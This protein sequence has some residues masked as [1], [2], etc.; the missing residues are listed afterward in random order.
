MILA[1]NRLAAGWRFHQQGK[2]PQA[3]IIYRSV[4]RDFPKRADAWVYLGMVLNDREHYHEALAAYEHALAI[5]P[6]NASAW[7][8]RGNTLG[9]LSRHI[10]A[11]A[12]HKKALALSPSFARGHTNLGVQLLR[13]GDMSAGW[14]EYD[15]RLKTAI[16]S[17]PECGIPF[18]KNESLHGK[19]IL[20]H[21]EQGLGDEIQ[22]AR[23]AIVL[24]K[25]QAQVTLTASPKLIPLLSRS[26]P[27]CE[28]IPRGGPLPLADY[29][30]C[31]FSLVSKLGVG[32][33][34][35]Y[36]VADPKLSAAWAADLLQFNGLKVGICW[37]G[38]SENPMNRARSFSLRSFV[39]LMPAENICLVSLQ[40]L[41]GQEE[42]DAMSKTHQIY[43]PLEAVN[44]NT[45]KSLDEMAALVTN[46]D[47][48][49]TCDSMTAHLAPALGTP[50]WLAL[51]A[52]PDWRWGLQSHL[53]PWYEKS[54]LFRQ[55]RLGDW[56]SVFSQI[57]KALAE[58][59]TNGVVRSAKTPELDSLLTECV[60]RQQGRHGVFYYLRD[61]IYIG[62]SLRHYGEFSEP[63]VTLFEQ[64]VKTGDTVVEVGSN[65][66]THTIPLGRMVG[67]TGKVLAFEPQRFIYQ[68]LQKNIAENQLT[69]IDARRVALADCPGT[70][71]VPVLDP[72]AENN[73][74]GVPIGRNEGGDQV[75]VAT[76]DSL[77]LSRCAL[78]KA[79]VEGMEIH[80]IRGASETIKK[81]KPILYLEND[82]RYQ[83]AELIAL[84]KSLGHR[85]YSHTPK[86]FNENNFFGNDNNI[87]NDICSQNILCVPLTKQL[88]IKGL[89]EL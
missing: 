67:E 74:G 11:L 80:V 24:A 39:E 61:D 83:S 75:S 30:I 89:N 12:S 18:W 17:P 57:G 52:G 54:Q 37:T 34:S 32:R 4:L 88:E 73:F 60:E 46:L 41:H 36:L 26:L 31:G 49:I 29:Q 5:E 14:Q 28:V 42:L 72:R 27:G 40:A 25:Q 76:L 65:I 81:C 50:T 87:F 86:L 82:R 33:A 6:E 68:L 79:D 44:G 35:S 58:V 64:F 63:E 3:E 62:K 15:W 38:N 45:I 10:D 43:R 16:F 56:D 85:V 77:N 84:V 1:K 53:S 22:T 21:G 51:S 9:L 2:L 78:I 55:K 23:Y 59:G 20:I 70:I 66:G 7:T 13:M 69:Q 47:L 71:N 19:H 8:N 48:V